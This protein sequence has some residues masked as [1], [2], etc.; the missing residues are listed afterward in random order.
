MQANKESIA[1]F[2]H[3]RFGIQ[4]DV[5]Y[6]CFLASGSPFTEELHSV[7]VASLERLVFIQPPYFLE[8]ANDAWRGTLINNNTISRELGLLD[9]ASLAIA[10]TL[11]GD[12]LYIK[13]VCQID[14][15]S[16]WLRFTDDDEAVPRNCRIAESFAELLVAFGG[17]W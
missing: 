7:Q 4:L 14:G 5:A 3:T 12:L 11:A 10:S 8:Y 2:I 6:L 1:S 15:G 16:V 9:T 13:S 17:R